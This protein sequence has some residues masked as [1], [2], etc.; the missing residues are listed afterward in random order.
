MSFGGLFESAMLPYAGAK[1]S[2]SLALV[3]PSLSSSIPSLFLIN[4]SINRSHLINSLVLAMQQSNQ[5]DHAAAMLPP[6]I[7]KDDDDDP[8]SR[9]GSDHL[10]AFSADDLAAPAPADSRSRKRKKR[11][12]RHTPQQI[13]ELEA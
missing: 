11:Y 5:L 4:C 1:Y 2:L 9:S 6:S 10:D 3:L 13:Q 12:H 7:S 8:D